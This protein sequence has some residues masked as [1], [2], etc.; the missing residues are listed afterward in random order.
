MPKIVFDQSDPIG[1]FLSAARQASQADLRSR[2]MQSQVDGQTYRDAEFDR[3]DAAA[4]DRQL[5]MESQRSANAQKM[6]RQQSIW[7]QLQR[8]QMAKQEV[9]ALTKHFSDRGELTPEIADQLAYY[10]NTGDRSNLQKR[11]DP[12]EQA[13]QARQQEQE[14]A[15][16]DARAAVLE[17]MGASKDQIARVVKSKTAFDNFERAFRE[18]KAAKEKAGQQDAAIKAEDEFAQNNAVRLGIGIA[19]GTVTAPI[20]QADIA[21]MDRQRF[22]RRR[23]IQGGF[24][25]G[26]YEPLPSE[27]P[28]VGNRPQ[29][30]AQVR[31]QGERIEETIRREA[32]QEMIN[33]GIDPRFPGQDGAAILAEVESRYAPTL[34]AIREQ[35]MALVG[36]P[37]PAPRPARFTPGAVIQPAAEEPPEVAGLRAQGIKLVIADERGRPVGVPPEITAKAVDGGNRT[38]EEALVWIK[39]YLAKNPSAGVRLQAQP[40]RQTPAPSR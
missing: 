29:S 34:N 32:N 14:Q 27:R 25:P 31:L 19:D 17:M 5:S 8:Q 6:A 12:Q 10:L 36:V 39:D 24:S 13:K 35:E 20:A 16:R 4:M 33:A 11:F 37:M 9:D 2:I 28:V 26:Q 40:T 21:A 30:L 1:D 23:L 38:K 18:Q 15:D 22:E 7:Q 3:R